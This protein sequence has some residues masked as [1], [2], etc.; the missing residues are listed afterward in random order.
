LVLIS[1]LGAPV[2]AHALEKPDPTI[3]DRAPSAVVALFDERVSTAVGDQFCSGV[4]VRDAWV[5]TAAHCVADQPDGGKLSVGFWIAGRRE[6]VRVRASYYPKWFRMESFGSGDIALLHLVR[7]VPG[8]RPIP[9][10]VSSYDAAQFVYGYGTSSATSVVERPLGARVKVRNRFGEEYFGID[11]VRQIAASVVST[12][13]VILDDGLLLYREQ[14][15]EGICSG[16]SGGPL[17]GARV[18][19]GR[20]VVIGIVSYGEE[21]CWAKTPGVYTRVRAYQNWINETIEAKK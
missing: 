14:L 15:I 11:P 4:L 1:V 7:S 13:V 5:L 16:D 8:V 6:L 18:T 12:E 19:D 2:T 3:S 9:I 17:L 20:P 21:P 10:G